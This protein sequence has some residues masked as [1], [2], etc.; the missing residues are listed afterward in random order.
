MEMFV[1]LLKELFLN[2]TM[3]DIL[4][5]IVSVVTFIV[6]G[7]AV[8]RVLRTKF[9]NLLNLF[10]SAVITITLYFLFIKVVGLRKV[11]YFIRALPHIN[12]LIK[13][14]VVG[15][16]NLNDAIYS[17]SIL[18]VMFRASIILFALNAY[19]VCIIFEI[20][21]RKEKVELINA[22]DIV[23]VQD[24]LLDFN[25]IYNKNSFKL[26]CSYSC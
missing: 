22:L 15:A 21:E 9:F 18:N 26:N 3:K 10:N 23:K 24:S 1:K 20:K 12:E 17:Y 2:Q 5:F 11:D 19:I 14:I 7:F 13:T 25:S 6:A 8:S 16:G 4:P